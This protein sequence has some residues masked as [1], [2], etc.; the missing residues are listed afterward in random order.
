MGRQSRRQAAPVSY[1]EE[2][3]REAEGEEGGSSDEG[4]RTRRAAA[5]KMKVTAL[6]RTAV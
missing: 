1:T 6:L 3:E 5:K 2:W 4:K